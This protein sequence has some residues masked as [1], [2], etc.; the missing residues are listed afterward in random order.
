MVA[1]R[2]VWKCTKFPLHCILKATKIQWVGD[3]TAR[4]F[5]KSMRQSKDK[6][7]PNTWL[8]VIK[9]ISHIIYLFNILYNTWCLLDSFPL[10]NFLCNIRRDST[11]AFAI[12]FQHVLISSLPLNVTFWRHLLYCLT[13]CFHDLPHG[14]LLQRVLWSFFLLLHGFLQRFPVSCSVDSSRFYAILAS[15]WC[16][17]PPY[18]FLLKKCNL[19]EK[20]VQRVSKSNNRFST[21]DDWHI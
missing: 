13:S 7:W 15:L 19:I 1:N 11:K 20:S 3:K 14:S 6:E 5:R 9:K 18:W 21:A 4:S 12:R 2:D 17:R 8:L 10:G 16:F